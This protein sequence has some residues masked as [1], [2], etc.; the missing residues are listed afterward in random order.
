MIDLAY[1]FPVLVLNVTFLFGFK[2]ALF[3]I[4]DAERQL[5]KKEKNQALLFPNGATDV[6]EER[7]YS[8][9]AFLQFGSPLTSQFLK[10]ALSL[11]YWIPLESVCCVQIHSK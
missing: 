5:F 9:D 2:F 1:F 3:K 8:S 11:V 6:S 4:T 7:A 10:I